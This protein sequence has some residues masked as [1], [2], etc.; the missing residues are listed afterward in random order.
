MNTEEY[1]VASFVAQTLPQN[2]QRLSDFIAKQEGIEVHAVNELGKIV[3]TAEG[4]SQRE[5]AN[6]TDIIKAHRDVLTFSPV[7]HQ[8]LNEEPTSSKGEL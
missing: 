6:R 7:Y 3:F 1:H 8:F 4:D 5:I 2:T